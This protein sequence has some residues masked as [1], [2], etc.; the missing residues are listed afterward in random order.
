MP[1]NIC[2]YCNRCFFYNINCPRLCDRRCSGN[3]DKHI[4]SAK[5][6]LWLKVKIEEF[7]EKEKNNIL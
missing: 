3:L 7:L 4:E 5:K 1:Y 2:K 6:D